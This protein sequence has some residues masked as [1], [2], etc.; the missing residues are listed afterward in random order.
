MYTSPRVKDADIVKS[1]IRSHG[2]MY[3]SREE[4]RGFG[5]GGYRYCIYTPK[6]QSKHIV[7]L[8]E[9]ELSERGM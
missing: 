1:I 2:I 8:L 5:N 4:D 7:N 6:K 9:E 3:R